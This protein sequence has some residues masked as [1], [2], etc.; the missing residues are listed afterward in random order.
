MGRG[1]RR[2][3]A[4]AARRR[5]GGQGV[6]HRGWKE[7]KVACCRTLASAQRD[8]APQPRP[9]AKFLDP[10]AVAKLVRQVKAR[11]HGGG[12]GRAANPGPGRAEAKG[13]GRKK[14][15]RG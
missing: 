1:G 5:G 4:P 13:G 8:T 11:G 15:R 2:R 7:T 10:P 3:R 6:Q 14:G 9:R 12:G